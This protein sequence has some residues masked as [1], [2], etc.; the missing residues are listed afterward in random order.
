M[1][2]FYSLKVKDLVKETDDCTSVCFDIPEDLAATFAYT[3][4]QYLTL[5]QT[6]NG[7]EVRRSYS[8]CSSPLDGE[9]RVAIKK[10]DGGKFSTFANEVLQVGDTLEAMPPMGNFFTPIAPQQAKNYVAF[11]AGSGIT[12]ILS[13]L[14]TVLK[15]EKNSTFTLFYLNR[16][17]SKIIFKETLEGLRNQYLQRFQLYYNLTKEQLDTPLFFGRYDETKLNVFFEKLI[18]PEEVDEFFLCGPEEMIFLIKKVLE[19]KKVDSKKIHFELFTSPDAQKEKQHSEKAV[20]TEKLSSQISI[21]DDG[22]TFIFDL[23]FRSD[24]ILD[25]ALRNGADLPYA[26]KGG[27]CC[28]CKAK[29]IEGEV[30]MLVNYALEPE[31]VEAGFILT[32]QSYPLTETVVVDFDQAM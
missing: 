3:Q 1:T 12:P 4:G 31:E 25:A 19:N 9:L 2:K 13:I 14:K 27:V 29:L 20:Q 30:D 26:C 32:C 6:I 28:T 7:A 22:K 21:K 15:T 17:V 11:A 10:I 18:R 24:N 5:R 23:P 16:N 8:V